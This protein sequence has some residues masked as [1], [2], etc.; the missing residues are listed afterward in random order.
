MEPDTLKHHDQYLPVLSKTRRNADE[1][2]GLGR[3]RFYNNN[4]TTLPRPTDHM[5][6]RSC[7]RSQELK[8]FYSFS[9]VRNVRRLVDG[10]AA[11]EN[12]RL[13]R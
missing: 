13:A 2:V 3:R 8:D 4:N 10:S 6:A 1:E 12:K 9:T 11:E 5:C 7:A